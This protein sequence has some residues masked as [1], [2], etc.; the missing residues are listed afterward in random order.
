MSYCKG[1]SCEEEMELMIDYC[2]S[3]GE[4]EDDAKNFWE[5]CRMIGC[6]NIYA[7]DVDGG[8]CHKCSLDIC[9]NHCFIV[10]LNRDGSYQKINC[11]EE[12][13]NEVILCTSCIEQM[14][15]D[16]K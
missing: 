13:D 6:H 11:D 10:E 5:H 14:R 1:E 9:G 7:K 16:N 8:V 4:S 2:I 15:A 3:L 12:Y